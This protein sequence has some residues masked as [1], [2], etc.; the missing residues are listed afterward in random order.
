MGKPLTPTQDL[1]A[2]YLPRR[3]MKISVDD[4][5]VFT[6]SEIEKKIIKNDIHAEKFEQD[7]RR[8]VGWWLF[9]EKVNRCFDRMKKE[10]EPKLKERGLASIPTARD[11]F[12]ELVF[13]QPDYKDRTQRETQSLNK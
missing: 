6:L 7:M 10:W 5:E 8:R 2:T 4:Q 1:A 3:Y 11:A 12:A 9:D 13:S